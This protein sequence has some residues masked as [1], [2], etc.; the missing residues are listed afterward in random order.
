MHKILMKDSYKL[1]IENQSR[2]NLAIKEVVRAE[3]PKLIKIRII[4]AISDS[5]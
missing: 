5:A 1:S 2:L 3:V 4:F